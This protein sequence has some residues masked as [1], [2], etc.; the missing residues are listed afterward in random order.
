MDW[1]V[2]WKG[3][4]TMILYYY[5]NNKIN[6]EEIIEFTDAGRKSIQF[7]RMVRNYT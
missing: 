3:K 1:R 6:S 5:Y 4:N 7:L 2:Q